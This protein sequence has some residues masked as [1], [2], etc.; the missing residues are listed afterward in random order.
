MSRGLMGRL[1]HEA[2]C[3]STVVNARQGAQLLG[4]EADLDCRLPLCAWKS[5][6]FAIKSEGISEIQ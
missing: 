2:G 3:S 1:P 6:Y 5:R 4:M